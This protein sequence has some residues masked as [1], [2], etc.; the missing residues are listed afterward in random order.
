MDAA[1]ADV[2]LVALVTIANQILGLLPGVA[3][4]PLTL[5][6]L[7]GWVMAPLVWLIGIPWAEAGLGGSGSVV[8]VTAGGLQ[9]LI[10]A[11][12]AATQGSAPSPGQ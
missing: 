9:G 11:S 10:A 5:Q 8:S 7:L 3:G 12:G 1:E 2:V 4:D 6:R